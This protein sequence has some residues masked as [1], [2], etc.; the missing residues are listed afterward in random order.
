MFRA[1][2]SRRLAVAAAG[3][4]LISMT[5]AC[6]ASSAN[7]AVCTEAAW[8]K[9][10]GDFTTAVTASAG[11]LTKYN[12]ATAKLTADLKTLAGTADGEVASA[13]NDLAAS[14]ESFKIDPND[15]AA[16]TTAL[17]SMTT[18]A[19]EATTKLAEACS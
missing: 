2:S 19:Q 6:G 5:A 13:L 16:A 1:L 10:L 3:I 17:G 9:P 8:S 18:K 7:S 4:A 15:P 12:D 14:F 11:D